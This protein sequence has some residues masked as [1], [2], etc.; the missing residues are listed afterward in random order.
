MSY[1]FWDLFLNPVLMSGFWGYL[2]A[3]LIKVIC[4][5]VKNRRFSLARIVGAGGM[6]SSHSAMVT[7]ASAAAGMSYGFTSGIWP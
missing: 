1:Y 7:A 5:S 4:D 3:Q 2:T 6:P